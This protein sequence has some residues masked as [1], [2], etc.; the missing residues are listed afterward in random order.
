M[1]KLNGY[2]IPYEFKGFHGCNSICNISLWNN[3][4]R[5]VVVFH[6]RDDNEGTSITNMSEHLATE[7]KNIF[8]PY[9]DDKAI[10]WF[11]HYCYTDIFHDTWDEITY[12]TQHEKYAH[13]K[14]KPSSLDFIE[15]LIED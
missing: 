6:E 4:E 5:A 12:E 1:S 15:S 14:R 9:F 10:H 8:L 2:T 13:P 11:E 7:I 3:D